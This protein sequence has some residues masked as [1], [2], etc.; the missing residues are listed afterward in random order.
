MNIGLLLL[1]KSGKQ[2]KLKF[3]VTL[4]AAILGTLILL[5][6]V[7]FAHAFNASVDRSTWQTALANNGTSTGADRNI[8]D[9][10]APNA[11]V[12]V[13]PQ[14]PTIS[15][16]NKSIASFTMHFTGGT[17]PNNSPLD[18]YPN[19]HEYYV[20]PALD[21]LLK[22]YPDNVLRNRFPGKQVGIIPQR[23]LASPDDLMIVSGIDST[24][25]AKAETYESMNAVRVTDFSVS[26]YGEQY[27]RNNKIALYAVIGIGTIGLV[28]PILILITTAT[29]LGARERETRYAALR[30]IG[31]TRQQLRRF[32]FIDSLSASLAGVTVGILLY[33]PLRFAML[34]VEVSG[35]RFYPSDMVIPPL[36]FLGII[37]FIAILVWV[38]GL[39]ALRGVIASPLG[40]ARR[41][42][43]VKEPRLWNVFPLIACI[44]GYAYLGTLT[45]QQASDQL[46]DNYPLYFVG[47]FFMTILS[48]LLSGSWIVKVY[49]QIIGRFNRKA[50]GV[51]IARRISFQ[52]RSIFLGIAGV[53]IAF[54]VGA[55]FIT[56]LATLKNLANISTPL[57]TKMVPDNAIVSD[58]QHNPE[59]N[60]RLEQA[61]REIGG[62]DAMPII[63]YD[64][65]DPSGAKVMS[66]KDVERLIHRSCAVGTQYITIPAMGSTDELQLDH[67][68]DAPIQTGAIRG[69]ETRI[70]LPTTA[71]QGTP[72]LA[73]H[74][75]TR[76]QAVAVDTNFVTIVNSTYR[77]GTLEGVLRN[78]KE[79]L[80][81]G[82]VITVII[83]SLNLVTATVAGV[84][85]RRG[86]FF[87]LR[88][89]GAEMPFL[90][91]I[92][93]GESMLPLVFMSLFSIMAGCLTSYVFLQLVA[94]KLSK[95]FVLPETYFWICVLLVFL[96]SYVGIRLILPMLDMLTTT[97]DNRTE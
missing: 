54:Y 86:S 39:L 2:G 6:V 3:I 4:A 9:L 38:A 87:T 13:Q 29:K 59:L 11:V 36:A 46:G 24:A 95:A 42:K 43:T 34:E 32:T 76:A 97:K 17:L 30:L 78:L 92:V 80:Y 82:I 93:L 53:A 77:T 16:L 48:L 94:V 28:F 85:D 88:L 68:V 25:L 62:Y 61:I 35:H 1:K 71:T 27:Q 91:N 65:G 72:L 64:S 12:S 37:A 23:A 83:A 21:A 41:Q 51:L 31:A 63:A 70:Y 57:L 66:C 7:S 81:A 69:L 18:H 79:L 96:M 45:K 58:G 75:L 84:F 5:A 60:N 44:A 14:F 67:G 20:S 52:A 10:T 55:F 49:G 19:N 40:V 22:Q 56:S 74:I 50:S 15:F 90:K 8:S 47:L 73:E 89:G 26:A 33:W